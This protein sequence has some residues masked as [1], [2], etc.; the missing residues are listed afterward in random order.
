MSAFTNNAGLYLPVE[1]EYARCATV[2]NYIGI[3]RLLPK[4]KRAGVIGIDG[5]EYPVPNRE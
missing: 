5:K 2:L 4:S 1:K 3:L